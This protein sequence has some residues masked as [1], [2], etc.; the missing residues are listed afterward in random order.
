MQL[1]L[2]TSHGYH[3]TLSLL[4][5]GGRGRSISLDSS[6]LKVV[7]LRMTVLCCVPTV[8]KLSVKLRPGGR[9]VSE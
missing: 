1:Q 6:S 2:D 8:S 5:K 3:E 4:G 9:Q 7:L